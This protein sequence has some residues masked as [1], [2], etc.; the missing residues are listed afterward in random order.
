LKKKKTGFIFLPSP[1]RG[2]EGVGILEHRADADDYEKEEEKEEEEY[3]MV[4]D[5]FT[6][7]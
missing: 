3:G 5:M 6:L 2:R 4:S 7:R 1:P